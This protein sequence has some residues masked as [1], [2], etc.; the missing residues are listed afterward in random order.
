MA[1]EAQ[2][3][4][5]A[6]AEAYAYDDDS[7][8]S[9]YWNNVLIPPHL[10]A[11]PEVRRHFQ[12]KFYQRFVD[13]EFVV[14]PLSSMKD[15]TK[16]SAASSSV[17]RGPNVTVNQR[18]AT[19]GTNTARST[20]GS[21]PPRPPRAAPPADG[22]LQLDQKSFQ[23]LNNAWVVVMAIFAIFPFLPRG[24]SDRGYRFSLAG[25]AIA[26]AHC[27]YL[28]NQRP[29]SWNLRGLQQWLQSVVPSKDFLS[30]MYSLIFFSSIHPIKFAVIPVFCRSLE[31]SATFLRR[32][33]SNTQ[34]YKRFLQRPCELLASNR[35]MLQMTSANSEIG[36]GFQLIFM[37][38]TPQRNLVQA[39][40]YWQLLKLFY[41][42]PYTSQ[43]HQQVWSRIG[44]KADPLIHRFAPVLERPLDYVR[45]WF[46]N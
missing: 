18:P 7:R 16:D 4:R 43:Y 6:A 12:L 9:D 15:G 27:L 40:I 10:S 44:A 5:R 23:F 17:P 35:T 36:I 22:T 37:I 13:P 46:L 8:W 33:F 45:N 31:E 38:I 29:R 30:F 42:A 28:N 3:G 34:L 26:C 24:I 14:E 19:T 21:A 11:K 2:G 32:N 1:G 39:L 25:N 20:A 41:R